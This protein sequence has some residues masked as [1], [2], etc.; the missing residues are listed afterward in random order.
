M[1]RILLIWFAAAV[2]VVATGATV[3][4]DDYQFRVVVPTATNVVEGATVLVNG[5]EAGEISAISVKDGKAVMDVTLDSEHAPLH[6]GAVVSVQWKA[7]LGERR[8][9][10]QD[11]DPS[12]AEIP[13]G[14]MLQGRMPKNVE[15]DEILNELDAGTRSELA[16]LLNRLNETVAGNEND[17]KRTLKS[18]GPAVNALGEV[19]R[20]VGSDGPA[21]KNLVTRLNTMVGTLASREDDL[22]AVVEG[23]SRS[24]S[25][26]VKQRK[27]LSKAL[28]AL[29]NTL[30]HA[31]KTLGKVPATVD[32][33]APLLKELTPATEKLPSVAKNLSP[34]LQD[35]RP[36]T[37][38]LR[39]SL[40]AVD[41]LL[42]FTPGLLDSAHEV[43]PGANDLVKDLLPAFDF[44]RPYTP[45]LTGFLS[46]WGSAAANY[47]SN[48]HYARI[49]VQGG[50][51]SGN[52]NP[53]VVPPGVK[54]N[55]HPVPGELEGQPWTDAY[56]GGPR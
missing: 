6:V 2:T 47:D 43:L 55:P 35:L 34:V 21:I 1:R 4:S 7:L 9:V 3:L 31:N 29:P 45:E 30:E 40:R 33:V 38:E 17:I 15:V 28:R 39:P 56:G 14:G 12:N 24:T 53:G 52:V 22:R 5:F 32:E 26:T 18:A 16:S 50:G 41:R 36:L 27:N 48:G 13:G 19:L 23:L 46:N 54:N 37:A 49:W 10:V 44:L 11:G 51:T 25:A 8:L 42:D 20:A